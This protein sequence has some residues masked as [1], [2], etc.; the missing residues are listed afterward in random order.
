V[1][2]ADQEV[3]VA[4]QAERVAVVDPQRLD[5]LELAPD[6]RVEAD[7][8]QPA[9]DAVVAGGV[10]CQWRPVGAAAADEAVAVGEA[11]VEEPAGVA[12]VAAADV[13]AERA[14]EAVGVAGVGEVVDRCRVG[15]ERRVWL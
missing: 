2:L 10:R 12:R 11:A 9:V 15:G 3:L 13:G 14:A 7:E 6:A 1:R 5:G 4:A 8:D